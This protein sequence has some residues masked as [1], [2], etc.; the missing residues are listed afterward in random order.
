MDKLKINGNWNELKGKVKQH[1]GS[2]T[3]DDLTYK[4]GREDEMIGKI[5][6]KTGEAREQVIKYIN[7]LSIQKT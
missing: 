7:G 4:E 3:D 6:K 1:W 2:L 5:Q